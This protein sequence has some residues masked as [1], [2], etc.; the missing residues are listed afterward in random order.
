MLRVEITPSNPIFR[1]IAGEI[2]A[3]KQRMEFHEEN[4]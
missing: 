1:N 4:A 3:N 2:K